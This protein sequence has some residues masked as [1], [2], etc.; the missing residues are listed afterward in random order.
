MI[1]FFLLYQMAQPFRRS[2]KCEKWSSL[3]WQSSASHF[4]HNS[5]S[6][7]GNH[8]LCSVLDCWC[9]HHLRTLLWWLTDSL[10]N[11][12]RISVLAK[13]ALPITPTNI[14]FGRLRFSLSEQ[15]TGSGLREPRFKFFFPSGCVIFVKVLHFSVPHSLWLST[16]DNNNAY[17]TGLL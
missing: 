14:I 15:E 12:L 2:D 17:L 10:G 16:G 4:C 8:D 6:M 7:I 3:S 1:L 11:S 5:S 9:P 13:D